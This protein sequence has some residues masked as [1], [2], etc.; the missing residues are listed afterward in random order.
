V[1]DSIDPLAG[2]YFI[3]SLTD[4]IERLASDYI[5]RIDSLGGA[6]SGIEHGYQQN[7]IQNAA[8][9][10]QMAIEKG[11]QVVVGVNQFQVK[12]EMTLERQV[13]DPAIEAEARARLARLRETRDNAKIVELRARLES[14]PK[15]QKT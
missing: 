8:Y 12:E 10:A 15:A 6:M 1:A 4:E 13:I 3:E 11:Q 9:E 5:A 2:S 14:P 7:E